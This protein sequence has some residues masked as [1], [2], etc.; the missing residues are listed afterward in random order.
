MGR[1]VILL[2]VFCLFFFRKGRREERLNLEKDGREFRK[3][4]RLSISLQET[5][6]LCNNPA[7]NQPEQKTVVGRHLFLP[8]EG[9]G[10]L[11][12]ELEQG[13]AKEVRGAEGRLFFNRPPTSP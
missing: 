3:N 9:H 2:F 12:K 6:F 4:T 11:L 13:K 1:K 10:W 8:P 5:W 7:H